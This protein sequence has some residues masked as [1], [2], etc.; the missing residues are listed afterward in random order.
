MKKHHR[1]RIFIAFLCCLFP[2]VILAKAAKPEESKVAKPANQFYKTTDDC[3]SC[4]SCNP[5]AYYCS[6]D[7][8]ASAVDHQKEEDQE[9]ITDKDPYDGHCC[10]E[11]D[12]ESPDWIEGKAPAG[13]G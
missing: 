4:L 9:D 11:A 8:K 5:Y 12:P 3:Y 10:I 7:F 13:D 1:I 2:V 6:L